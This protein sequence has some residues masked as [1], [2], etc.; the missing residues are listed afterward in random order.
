MVLKYRSL[1][2]A[3]SSWAD[4]ETKTKLEKVFFTQIVLEKTIY[5]EEY[6][7]S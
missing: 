7:T 3:I 6:Q 1:V 5:S 2:S 4:D